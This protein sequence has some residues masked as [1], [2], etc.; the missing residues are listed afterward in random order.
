MENNNCFEIKCCCKRYNRPFEQDWHGYAGNNDYFD[1]NS[2][3]FDRNS[4]KNDCCCRRE[5]K[6][7][8]W[9][10]EKRDCCRD[11]R[12]CCCRDE[13]KDCDKKDNCPCHNTRKCCF[14]F[15]R[16]W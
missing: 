4:N 14:G 13:H 16:C 3:N 9:H 15:F 2:F 1:N 5:E 8:C 12:R 11:E 6:R 10:E 7:D